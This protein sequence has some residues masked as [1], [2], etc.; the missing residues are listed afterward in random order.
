MGSALEFTDANFQ[1]EVIDSP[2]PVLVDFWA[3]WC[4]PCR[5]IGPTIEELSV[6]NSGTFRIGKV[7]VDENNRLAM[8]YNVQSIPTIMIFNGGQLVQQFMGV[9]PKARLQQALDE[10]K[11]A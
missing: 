10:A 2:V 9:Q 7:N 11:S 6:E 3:P 5:M 1:S 4:G 8:T